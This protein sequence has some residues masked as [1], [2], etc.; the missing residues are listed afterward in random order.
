ML[1]DRFL[2]IHV[3]WYRRGR[4]INS[5]QDLYVSSWSSEM[6]AALVKLSQLDFDWGCDTTP[7]PNQASPS[8]EQRKGGQN[9]EN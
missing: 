2:A 7:S 9:G 4:E 1:A 6:D 8:L 5:L 3:T